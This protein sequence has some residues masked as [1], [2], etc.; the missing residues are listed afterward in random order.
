MQA[1]LF[2]FLLAYG[3]GDRRALLGENKEFVVGILL[4]MARRD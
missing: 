3:L 1:L 2:G 4:A